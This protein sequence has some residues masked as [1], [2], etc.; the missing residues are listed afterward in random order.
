VDAPAAERAARF[1]GIE[2]RTVELYQGD[3]LRVVD[4]NGRLGQGMKLC[5]ETDFWEQVGAQ[6]AGAQ[7]GALFVGDTPFGMKKRRNRGRMDDVLALVNIY[8]VD[9]IEWFLDKLPSESSNEL[10][11]GWQQNLIKLQARIPA[12]EDYRDAQAYMYLDQRIAN[13]LTLWRECFQMPYVR[14][15]SPFIDNDILDFARTIPGSLREGKSLYKAALVSSFPQL[16][17]LPIAEGGFGLPT[18][19]DEIAKH[20]GPI[21]SSLNERPS[22]L[23]ELVP[24]ETI[25]RLVELGTATLAT[26]FAKVKVVGK[27]V[28]KR[29]AFARRL[30]RTLNTKLRPA[31]AHRVPWSELALRLLF[32]REFLAEPSRK[33]TV[34]DGTYLA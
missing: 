31:T 20:L 21:V 12:C 25:R 24:P 32:L 26:G 19:A 13:F 9:G 5:K 29:S 18:F 8:P 30:F 1:L 6:M 23:D 2:Q 27:G 11:E 10:R 15:M 7:G 16:Y 17:S 22:Q 4:G 34:P 14:V 3:L 28:P 33:S